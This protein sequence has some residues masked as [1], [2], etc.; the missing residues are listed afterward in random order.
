MFELLSMCLIWFKSKEGGIVK[1]VEWVF[2]VYVKSFVFIF[3]FNEV[4]VFYSCFKNGSI[5]V[6]V[7]L[8]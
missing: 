4:F 6:L 2:I 3:I 8:W 7:I 1:F 5:V